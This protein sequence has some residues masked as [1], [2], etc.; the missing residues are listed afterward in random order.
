MFNMDMP[1]DD[2]LK[3]SFGQGLKLCYIIEKNKITYYIQY[4]I[5]QKI[6]GK[7]YYVPSAVLKITTTNPYPN[8]PQLGRLFLPIRGGLTTVTTHFLA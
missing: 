3:R 2:S 4:C 5:L 1:I 8:V 7:Y 6:H